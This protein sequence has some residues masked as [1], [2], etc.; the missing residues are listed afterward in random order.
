MSVNGLNNALALYDSDCT[1]FVY[2]VLITGYW[3]GCVWKFVLFVQE[4]KDLCKDMRYDVT[5]CW[6]N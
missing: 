1:T 3:Q 2:L 5:E 6:N 4:D